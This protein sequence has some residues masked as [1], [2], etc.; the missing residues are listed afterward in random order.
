MPGRRSDHHASRHWLMIALFALPLGI[1]LCK[2]WA[3]PTSTLFA[4]LFSLSGLSPQSH[5]A[6]Q[7]VLAVPIGALVVVLFRLTLGLQMLG[8]FRPIL[9]AIAFGAIGVPLSLGFL[10]VALLGIG[11][12]RPLL[13]GTH[14]YARIA[15]LLSLAACLL[16]SSLMLGRWFDVEWMREAVFFP[17]IALGLTCEAFAKTVDRC[18]LQV[19]AWRTAIT[20]LAGLV[21]TALVRAPAVLDVFL[22]F[23]E[24]LLAQ[25][26]GILL[27]DRNLAFRLFEQRNPLG[28]GERPTTRRFEPAAGD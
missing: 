19:A 17:V 5:A 6:V 8:L 25:A 14:N 11:L 16:L 9:L 4:G 23:P 21:I 2:L 28:L 3:P 12:L 15:A 7:N 20:I 27:V 13:T 10:G 18:G 26:G 22:R 24:V 1:A